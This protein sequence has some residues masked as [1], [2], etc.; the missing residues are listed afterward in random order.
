MLRALS[1]GRNRATRAT[2]DNQDAH[3]QTENT[4]GYGHTTQQ[5]ARDSEGEL[6]AAADAVL[7]HDQ[8][9]IAEHRRSQQTVS[10]F[11]FFGTRAGASNGPAAAAATAKAAEATAAAARQQEQQQGR[12]NHIYVQ[13]SGGVMMWLQYF[14]WPLPS[15]GGAAATAVQKKACRAAAAYAA[16]A[17]PATAAAAVASAV[18]LLLSHT[19]AADVVTHGYLFSV[20]LK[21]DAVLTRCQ[22]NF[23]FFDTRFAPGILL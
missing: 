2:R 20:F 9:C 4:L 21:Y 11:V 10:C 17:A 13:T 7:L 23:P 8:R 16:F 15:P 1:R 3:I 6:A 12:P 5:P 18:L 14:L 22:P 19:G